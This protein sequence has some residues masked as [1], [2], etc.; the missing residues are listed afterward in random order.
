MLSIH[1]P[2]KCSHLINVVCSCTLLWKYF[3]TTVWSICYPSLLL[4]LKVC[5]NCMFRTQSYSITHQLEIGIRFMDIRLRHAFDKL[6]VHHGYEDPKFLILFTLAAPFTVKTTGLAFWQSVWNFCKNIL[7]KLFLS[8]SNR[9][10]GLRVRNETDWLY[11]FKLGNTSSTWGK[12]VL[13]N[14]FQ[15]CNFQHVLIEPSLYLKRTVGH[16]T[17]FLLS[18]KHVERL[19]WLRGTFFCGY[20][21]T[22]QTTQGC[23]TTLDFFFAKLLSSSHGDG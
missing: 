3:W 6:H 10:T 4:F 8:R 11:L 2:S 7:L 16:T 18:L 5:I 14:M 15:V 13:Q 1:W 12:L 21:C 20:K 17:K 23:P 9:S 22:T 19:F